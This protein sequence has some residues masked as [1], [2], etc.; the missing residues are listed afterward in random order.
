LTLPGIAGIVLT[1]GMAV[2]A[3][4]IINERV[5][6]ELRAGKSLKT[7]ISEGFKHSY[8]GHYRLERNNDPFIFGADV[9]WSWPDQRI[10]C[11]PL[12]RYPDFDVHCRIVEPFDD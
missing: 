2:D 7:A 3:N 8:A 5:R 11:G 6:E 9:F 4:V 1:M 10:C 12:N